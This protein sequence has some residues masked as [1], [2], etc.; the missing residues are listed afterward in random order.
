MSNTQKLIA[1]YNNAMKGNGY[2]LALVDLGDI[3]IR[4]MEKDRRPEINVLLSTILDEMHQMKNI[5][6][7]NG[8]TPNFKDK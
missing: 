7:L 1:E 4:L 2:R 5:H 6:E 3:L 8:F